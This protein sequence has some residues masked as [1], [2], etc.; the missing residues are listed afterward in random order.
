V[1]VKASVSFAGYRIGKV[2]E[3]ADDDRNRSLLGAGYFTETPDDRDD[4]GSVDDLPSDNVV[5]SEPPKRRGRRVANGTSQ[6]E[7]DTEGA[8]SPAVHDT[9]G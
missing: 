8:D 4:H 3:V 1:K 6:P 7:P 5:V 9:A 2:Y